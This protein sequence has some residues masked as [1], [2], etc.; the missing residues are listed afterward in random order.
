MS[1]P[2]ASAGGLARDNSAS[3]SGEDDLAIG[4]VMASVSDTAADA[5]TNSNNL[6]NLSGMFKTPKWVRV[7]NSG[8]TLPPHL[9]RES[10]CGLFRLR[11]TLCVSAAFALATLFLIA[12]CAATTWNSILHGGGTHCKW[13]HIWL[14]LFCAGTITLP[15]ICPVAA[16][17]TACWAAIGLLVQTQCLDV[18]GHQWALILREVLY[19]SL[20]AT[21]CELCAILGVFALK[22]QLKTFI[23]RWGTHRELIRR[24]RADTAANLPPDSECVICCDHGS[25]TSTW[26]RLRCGHVFHDACLMEWLE[27]SAFTCP[28]CRSDL[29]AAYCEPNVAGSVV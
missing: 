25:P 7:L 2:S 15:F 20:I 17:V 10:K 8:S 19:R 5:A 23:Q 6:Q 26:R 28:L 24:I 14:N 18:S 13:L 3:P 9:P 27:T 12:W 29:Y 21:G 1:L 16:P 11:A 4:E 22:M